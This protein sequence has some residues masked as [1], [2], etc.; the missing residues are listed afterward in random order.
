MQQ[1]HV[2]NK[3]DNDASFSHH[4][5][6]ALD[7]LVGLSEIRKSIPTIYHYDAEGSRLFDRITRLTEYYPTR[8]EL[9]TLECNKT[10]IAG[11][12]QTEPFNLV[13]FGSGDGSKTRIIIEELRRQKAD[14]QFVPIDISQTALEGLIDDYRVRYPDL[15]INGLACDY[16]AGVKWLTNHSERS[17]FVLFLGSNIGNFNHR[18]ARLFLRTLW[19]CLNNSDHLLIGFDLKKDIELLERAYNDSDGVTAEFNINILR[20]INKELGG[21]FDVF[22][23]RH[24]GTYDVFTGA[25]ESY[26]VSLVSQD[27]F[28]EEVGRSFHFDP[29][30]P[31]H[32]EYSYKYHVADIDGLAVDTGFDVIEHLF[33]N[34]RYFTDSVWRVNKKDANSA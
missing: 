33:D 26:L 18:D 9:E 24:F 34:K 25:M 17:N 29:W 5:A 21:Q 22:K 23:F 2:L 3:S 1:I 10:K 16:F 27:V 4:E 20:R 8:C 11:F 6:F 7:V 19:N 28:I 13:E 15:H 12:A 14:F 31:I 30:E 32:V